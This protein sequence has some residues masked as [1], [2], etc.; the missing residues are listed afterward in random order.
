MGH[1]KAGEVGELPDDRRPDQNSPVPRPV[2]GLIALAFTGVLIWHVVFDGY[3][4]AYEGYKVT[5]LLSGVVLAI[6]GF[7]VSKIFRGGGGS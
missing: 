5:M 6:I 1:E 3:N 4:D 2:V 7:D